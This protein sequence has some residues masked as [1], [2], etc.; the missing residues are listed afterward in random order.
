[1]VD[2]SYVHPFTITAGQAGTDI[3]LVFAVP[4]PTIGTWATDNGR[5]MIFT[6]CAA[7]WTTYQAPSTDTWV[8]GSFFGHASM[9]NGLAA[10]NL[11]H[12]FDAGIYLDPLNTGIAPPF[13]M[14]DEAQ[15]LLNC[16]R[17]WYGV[18]SVASS[19][20]MHY[21]TAG[22]TTAD[23]GS[24]RCPVN[25]RA[26][27]AVT[28]GTPTL[29]NCSALAFVTGGSS[30]EIESRVTVTAAGSYRAQLQDVALNARM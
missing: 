30:G 12:F 23:A 6:I 28:V 29:T 7:A 21:G 17:Y 10:T 20:G 19:L 15:E 26:I 25:M 16:Q 1:V 18:A 8:A 22:M 2:A 13:A 11:F 14:P 3:E 4:A 9:S 5:G 24:F 27:P